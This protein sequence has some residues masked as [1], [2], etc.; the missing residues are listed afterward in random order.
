MRILITGAAGFIG[1]HLADN[2]LDDGFDV[3]GLDNYNDY[4]DPALKR[5][6][7]A[8]FGHQVYK[9]DLK[10]FD[11]V[12]RAFNKLMPDVVIH[13]AA[14]AGV[15]DSVGNEQLY[16]QD[17]II[18]TQNL[19]QVCKMYKVKKVLYA[20]TSSVYGGTPIP[21]TGWT[22]DEVTGHQLNPYAY[23]KYC[24][25]CQFKISGLNNVGLRFFTVYGPWGRPDMA[26]YQFA[27]SIVAGESIEA[28]NYGE[29]KRDFTY[30]GDII[31]GI[32]LAL[33]ADLPSGEIFNIGR[34]KQVELMHFIDCISKELGRDVDVVL[35]PRHPADTLETWSD[36]AKLRELGYKPKVNIEVGVAAFIKW[37]KDYYGVN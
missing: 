2:L 6:R 19:I 28:Y 31:E 16:H 11:E 12:D 37:Y 30:V 8:Y 17:N 15:R 14:R 26:L 23:T 25:E 18:A 21:P 9:A 20:S 32:K 22:E 36:T 33:F 10:E 13:L 29:M 1:S 4:Y 34:G 3:V 24:N 27:D 7:V 35:A 5:D